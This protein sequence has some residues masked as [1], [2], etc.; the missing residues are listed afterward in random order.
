[1]RRPG[2][3]DIA[4]TR[5]SGRVMMRI[6][7]DAF[8]ATRL[9]LIGKL[10]LLGEKYNNMRWLPVNEGI[11]M[12]E[13]APMPADIIYRFIDEASR[14]AILNNCECRKVYDCRHHPTDIGCLFLG[15]SACE[16]P[17]G[18]FREASVEEAR[19]HVG[20]ALEAGLVPMVGKNF[21]DNVLFGIKER[22]K[23]LSIC[24]C[25]E[26]CCISRYV[27]HSPSRVIDSTFPRLEGVTVEVTDECTGCGTC[28]D[29]C[30]IQAMHVV[31][32]RAV[33]AESCRACG[34]CATACPNHAIR[35]SIDDPEYLNKCYDQIRSLIKF[36]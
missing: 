17:P 19:E 8:R 31:G 15:D 21:I 24:F 27:R 25:C 28:V 34:R 11:R 23:L 16:G 5:R 20:R 36:D 10:P 9:P 14:R 3:I 13:D 32:G 29:H 7:E 12:H 35:V 22:H 30:Y 26:C 6:I 2:L 18:M 1:M 4:R 33:M